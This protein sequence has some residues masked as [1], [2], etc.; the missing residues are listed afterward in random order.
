MTAHLKATVALHGTPAHAELMITASS[1]WQVVTERAVAVIGNLSTSSE[2]F[3]SLREAG[4]LQRLVRP[5]RADHG[6]QFS[7][8]GVWKARR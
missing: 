3:G 4:T 6:T 5:L 8:C 2:Y 7:A 1:D